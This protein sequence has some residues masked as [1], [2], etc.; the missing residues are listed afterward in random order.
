MLSIST[1]YFLTLR[2]S[3]VDMFIPLLGAFNL[4]AVW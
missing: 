4:A 2:L 3:N 1:K